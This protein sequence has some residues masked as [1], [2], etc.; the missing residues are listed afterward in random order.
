MDM[1]SEVQRLL[2]IS[3]NYARDVENISDRKNDKRSM[4]FWNI[5]NRIR[6]TQEILN[7][8]DRYWKDAN[9]EMTGE[10]GNEMIE[11]IVTV[12][13]NLFVDIVSMIEKTSK[14]SVDIYDMSELRKLSLGDRNYMYMRNILH[15]SSE[16]GIISKGSMEEWDDILVMRNL[17]AHNNSESDRSRKFMISDIVISMRPGRMMKGPLNTFL[18]FSE[19]SIT[20]FYEWLTA[21]DRTK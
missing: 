1:I 11:R 12:T 13:K 5:H 16:L 19:R 4:C 2:D 6:I 17:A 8:Y 14:E 3:E 21:V 9:I 10:N 7:F 15:A 18:V 20:L